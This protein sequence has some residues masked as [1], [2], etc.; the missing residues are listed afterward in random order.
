MASE[1]ERPI[2]VRQVHAKLV[3]R[4]V[5]YLR[6][7]MHCGRWETADDLAKRLRAEQGKA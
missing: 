6:R 4:A 3:Q 7:K 5:V 1:H 2:A